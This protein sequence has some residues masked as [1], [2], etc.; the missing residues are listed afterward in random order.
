MISIFPLLLAYLIGSIPTGFL[1]CKIKGCDIRTLGSKNIGATNVLRTGEKALALLTLSIDFLKGILPILFAHFICP[2]LILGSAFLVVL[3]HIFPIWLKFKGGK[4]V[5]TTLGV[6]IVLCPKLTVIII[7]AWFVVIYFTK[8]SSIAS[9]ISLAVMPLFIVGIDYY[10][11]MM[12]LSYNVVYFSL[13][14]LPIIIYTHLN[15]IKRL[16][17]AEEYSFSKE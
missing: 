6:Y 9:I 4:G 16:Y 2:E 12:H 7:L 8:T 1:L 11:N 13:V 5:A 15:N 17:K 3:G 10:F 14:M